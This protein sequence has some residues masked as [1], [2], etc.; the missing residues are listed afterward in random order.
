MFEGG[1]LKVLSWS[2]QKESSALAGSYGYTQD[3]VHVT[4][5]GQQVF[6]GTNWQVQGYNSR[7]AA[8]FDQCWGSILLF[9][10]KVGV[11]WAYGVRH[12]VAMHP[13]GRQFREGM[14]LLYTWESRTPEREQQFPHQPTQPPQ[15]LLQEERNKAVTPKERRKRRRG[16]KRA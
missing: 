4:G 9:Q 10:R 11:S 14:I 8:Q 15:P 2:R 3:V 13:R 5:S 12:G 6:Q 7:A 1:N 16:S